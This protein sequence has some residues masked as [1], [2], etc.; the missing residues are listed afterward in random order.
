MTKK[1]S[2]IVPVYNCEKY[3]IECLDSISNQIYKNFEVI[4]IDDGSTDKSKQKIESFIKFDNRFKYYYQHNNGVSSARNLG[5]IKATGDYCCFID[6]DDLIS[7]YYLAI[8]INCME[9][10]NQDLVCCKY[11][12]NE[13]ELVFNCDYLKKCDDVNSKSYI[14][15]CFIPRNNIAAF[16]WNRMY[17][18]DILKKE[19]IRFKESVKV[20]E[21]TLFNLEYLNYADKITYIDNPLYFY[22]LNESSTMF[23]NSF[24]PAKLTAIDAYELMI[25]LVNPNYIM[26]INICYFAYYAVLIFQIFKYKYSMSIKYYKKIE[27]FF[28]NNKKL[29]Y[30]K[31][32]KLKY[33]IFFLFR[34]PFF[35]FIR[36]RTYNETCCNSTML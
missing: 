6:A 32:I 14:K 36:K 7:K 16:V 31:D 24:N 1:I 3:I 12:N 4:L 8:L 9:T 2:V 33:K 11:T 19:N 21:D 18:V 26:Y 35:Y 30:S 28:L 15:E 27:N 5:I 25:E 22:R 20:S 10:F 23:N 17:K 34:K 13:D 29:I